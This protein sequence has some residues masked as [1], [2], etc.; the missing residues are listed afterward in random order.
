MLESN[1]IPRCA[2][3]PGL[4]QDHTSGGSPWPTPPP[5]FPSQRPVWFP[6]GALGTPPWTAKLVIKAIEMEGS[7]ES[8]T[9]VEWTCKTGFRAC[10]RHYVR[11]LLPRPGHTPTRLLTRTH[12]HTQEA[13]WTLPRRTGSTAPPVTSGF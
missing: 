11:K 9:L 8:G 3:T 4:G 10:I 2:E 6:R 7:I 5:T 12:A 13:S 1:R